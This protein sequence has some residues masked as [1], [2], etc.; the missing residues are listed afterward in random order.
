MVKWR[1]KP[2]EEWKE[3]QR[4][5]NK[6]YVECALYGAQSVIKRLN[7]YELAVE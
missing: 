4:L 5:L 1:I 2:E 6:E 3:G 7:N